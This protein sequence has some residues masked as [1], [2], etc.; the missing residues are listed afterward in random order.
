MSVSVSPVGFLL[1]ATPRTQLSHLFHLVRP[2]QQLKKVCTVKKKRKTTTTDLYSR[3]KV[4]HRGDDRPAG[5][6]GHCRRGSSHLE[7]AA[8]SRVA[9]VSDRHHVVVARY[10]HLKSAKHIKSVILKQSAHPEEAACPPPQPR[11]ASAGNAA[12]SSDTPSY[13]QTHSL[14]LLEI[15]G[16][17]AETQRSSSSATSG[18]EQA[19][20][21]GAELQDCSSGNW[22]D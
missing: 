3:S 2:T 6:R 7:K 22:S 19:E 21:P 11:R 17:N 5:F 9:D 13:R 12:L 4:G 16:A 18:R 10:L 20:A 15:L 14:T 8:N 1:N